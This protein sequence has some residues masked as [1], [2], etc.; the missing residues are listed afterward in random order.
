MLFTEM[1]TRLKSLFNLEANRI[2]IPFSDI[3]IRMQE[4]SSSDGFFIFGY[5]G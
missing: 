5:F 4:F 2:N 1:Y 3:S